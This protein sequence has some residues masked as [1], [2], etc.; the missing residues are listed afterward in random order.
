MATA[1]HNL[2]TQPAASVEHEVLALYSEQAPWVGPAILLPIVALAVVCY[3]ATPHDLWLAWFGL[4]VLIQVLRTIVIKDLPERQGLSLK[5][6]L[7]ICAALG[8]TNAIIQSLSLLVFPDLALAERIIMLLILCGFC[9]ST[10]STSAG[11]LPVFLAYVLPVSTAIS[12]QILHVSYMEGTGFEGW[13][14]AFCTLIFA[15]FLTRMARST[16]LMHENGWH[17]RRQQQMLND[18]LNQALKQAEQAN[19]SKTRFLAA[20][21]HDLRQPIH[22]MSLF[23]A[24]LAKQELN[25]KSQHMVERMNTAIDALAS[26]LDSILDISKLDA[27]VVDVERSSVLLS[28]LLQRLFQEFLPL[29]EGKN[30]QLKLQLDDDLYLFTDPKLLERVLRNLLSNAI[31]YT[32]H[33]E[34][35]LA[36]RLR[37]NSCE[38][39]VSDTGPGIP[40]S[41]QE[42]IYEEFYQ[43]HNPERDR[44]Q[45]LGL[46]LSIVKRLTDMLGIEL[47]LHSA[48]TQ[49]SRFLLCCPAASSQ[50]TT[51]KLSSATANGWDQLHVLAIDDEQ[52]ILVGMQA[53]LQ[54][55][56]CSVATAD[57]SDAAVVAA[58]QQAPDI[59]LA[60][61]RLRGSDSGL[62]AIH[63][64]RSIY[65][66]IPA[67]LISGDTEPA[68]LKQAQKAGIKLLHKP[69]SGDNLLSEIAKALEAAT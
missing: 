3:R 28:Q 36:A 59:V 22:A 16:W 67:L 45:G 5:Q 54:G 53:L 20:A 44:S 38:I 27:K 23:G 25:D 62:T 19:K 13:A 29:A 2:K 40:T 14:L 26:Q 21:S 30:L 66:N 24:S 37:G 18:D 42:K 9:A 35:V 31:K 68:R 34:V 4:L 11:Y 8:F 1:K 10:V 39:S 33:G 41:E 56:G 61:F 69:I 50:P 47:S 7:G 60:D 63:S 48:P 12:V 51:A 15:I 49:G 32:D 46:G 52:E 64:L 55:Y 65:P 17:M 57:S 6:K 43:L 58:S